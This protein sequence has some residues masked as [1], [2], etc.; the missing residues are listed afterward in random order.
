M[1]YVSDSK[2]APVYSSRIPLTLD[3]F[4]WYLAL[5]LLSVT[6]FSFTVWP[7]TFPCTRVQLKRRPSPCQ[8]H[9]PP[10]PISSRPGAFKVP[11]FSIWAE[12]FH[13]S[14]FRT[15]RLD[16]S[17]NSLSPPPRSQPTARNRMATLASLSQGTFWLLHPTASQRNYLRIASR[18]LRCPCSCSLAC[19]MIRL[20]PFLS[21]ALQSLG[22]LL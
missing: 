3:L 14:H 5:S 13:L 19:A 16:S 4:S 1:S 7:L 21:Q 15:P 8:A 2:L 6:V 10:S 18:T 22:I 17:T 20:L 12:V 11:S 9:S